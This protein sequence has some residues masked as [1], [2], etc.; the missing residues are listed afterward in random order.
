MLVRDRLLGGLV[1]VSDQL[2]PDEMSSDVELEFVDETGSP[3]GDRLLAGE[4]DDCQDV[5]G[6]KGCVER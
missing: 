5:V 3:G 2:F 1:E 6:E 4:R